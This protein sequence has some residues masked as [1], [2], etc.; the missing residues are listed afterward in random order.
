MKPN[1]VIVIFILLCFVLDAPAAGVDA[2]GGC[3]EGQVCRTTKEGGIT[4]NECI[5]VEPPPP[6]CNETTCPPPKTCV[7]DNWARN[8]GYCIDPLEEKSHDSNKESPPSSSPCEA[9][10]YA[11]LDTCRA[12][13]QGATNSCDEK[14]DPGIN[15]VSNQ[16]SQLAV[17]MGQMAASSIQAACS[18]MA[19]IS[20][21]ANAAVAA[22]QL[23]CSSSIDSCKSSCTAARNYAQEN[24]ICISGANAFFEGRDGIASSM[25]SMADA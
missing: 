11:R 12:E 8:V 20:Q 1:F 22:Y 25:L 4:I 2:C 7:S 10:F 3:Y 6:P 17:T 5:A 19:K 15:N 18:K 13:L 23:S 16:A 21:G 24:A 14:Q 9:E